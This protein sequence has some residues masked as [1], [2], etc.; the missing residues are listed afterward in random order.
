MKLIYNNPGNIRPGQDFAGETGEFYTAEDGSQYVIFDSPEM[1]LRALF[2]DLRLKI[3]QFNGNIDNIVN[4]YAPPADN[5]PT[6]SYVSFVKGQLG[7]ETVSEDDL[8]ELVSAFVRFENKKS[9][10]DQYLAPNILQTAQKL[11]LED[12]P[13]THRLSDAL[14]QIQ[15]SEEQGALPTLPTP[16]PDTDLPIITE[17]QPSVATLD[18]EETDLP[19]ITERQRQL[20][21]QEDTIANLALE[22]R[23]LRER[24]QLNLKADETILTPPIIEQR[25]NT[26]VQSDD[27]QLDLPLIEERVRP[28]EGEDEAA[29]NIDGLLTER[30]EP[31]PLDLA[32]PVPIGVQKEE[33]DK[34]AEKAPEQDTIGKPRIDPNQIQIRRPFSLLEQ[35]KAERLYE[36]DRAKV[37]FGQAVDAAFAEENTMSW[38][39]SG[40][41]DYEPNP[42]FRLTPE[43]I[44]E[45]TEGIPEDRRRFITEAVS[46]PH[47]QKLRERAL[48]SL[49]NQETLTKYGWGG[50]GLQVAAATL[51]VPAIAATVFTE[52]ALAPFIWGGKATRLARTFRAAASSGASAAAIESYLVSQNAM[53]D[54]YDILYAAA[55][56]F[57][58]GGTTD[59]VF[60]A[61]SRKRYRDA[62][63]KTMNDVDNAQAAD[64]NTAMMDRGID[65]GVGA[66]VNPLSRPMQDF[67]IRRGTI[68]QIDET[69][70]EPMAF[71]G[72]VRFDIVGQLKSSTIGLTRRIA[73]ILGEDAVEPG[74]FTADLIK[75]VGTKR[76]TNKFYRT[77]DPAYNE[78]AKSS[79]INGVARRVDSRKSEFGRL[80]SDEV[81]EPGSSTNPHIIKAANNTRSLFKNMLEEA[82]RAEV[83]GFDSIPENPKYFSHLWDGHRYLQAKKDFGKLLPELLKKSLLTANRTL[84][85]DMADAIAKGMVKKI[86]KRE[87]GM[88]AGLSRMFSTS[89]KEALRD[90]L[91]EE[92]IVTEAQADRIINQLDFD[93]E[94]VSP[95]ARRR[96]EFDLSASVELN[97][98]TLHIKD[99]M[100]RDTEAVVNAYVNQMQGRI[101]LAKKGIK[102]DADFE[103]IKKDIIAA[104]EELNDVD[105]AARDIQKL[106]VLHAL[107]SGRTSPL[108]A[109]PSSDGNRVIRLLM[110]YSFIR[111][112]N[113]VGFAQVAELGNAVSIDG[114]T[115]LLRVIP[116]WRAMV[117]RTANGELEDR[118]SRELEALVAPGVDRNIHSALNKFSYEDMYGLGKGDIIDKAIGVMQPLKRFTADISGLAGITALFERTAAKIA[119][120]SLVDLASGVRKV[121]MKRLGNS[122]LDQDIARRLKSLGLDEEMWPRVVNQIKQH[123]I[124]VPSMFS[125]KRKIKA[126]NMDDW[127]DLDARD[128][129]AYSI[130]RW[131]RQS[132]QQ[133][134]V[135]NLNIHMTSTM[136]KVLTQ[137]RAFMLVSW[138]KQFLHNIERRDFAAFSSM[139]WSL[140][141]GGNA[142]ILQTHVNALGREDKR[143]FLEERLS[144]TEIGKAAFV[145]SSWASLFPSAIDT[146]L[147]VA[148]ADPFFGF[149]RSTGLATDLVTGNPVFDLLDTTQSVVR[150]GSRALFNEEYQW[151]R[152]QQRA[153]NSLLFFQN[154]IGVKNVLNTMMDGL[155]QSA[156]VTE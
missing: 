92:E 156:R 79:G 21:P 51:D 141:Y 148:G 82:K 134:D 16:K 9:L 68:E 45:L 26:Q 115:A 20:V 75:T 151:S 64:V 80:V 97:G 130:A 42:D 108:I 47:A 138:S 110:D 15:S 131:T 89:N 105:Q 41:P 67:D 95:R 135:G 85:E 117:A 96:L 93:R 39:F 104:G 22:K 90:I 61:I 103:K 81:E 24:Q 153:L 101:A 86:I 70:A 7:K 44:A 28:T 118:V 78:W 10:A 13:Q 27:S 142:Y 25:Q 106:E 150:G 145:R 52:G 84:E 17:R 49:K 63:L 140:F 46:L 58:L 129:L 83:K 76:V 32:E 66:M 88:D 139:M 31:N 155:P 147:A 1:G 143:E 126:I 59:S 91:L 154:A 73:S 116:E 122:S 124:S 74:E 48:A 36:E 72:K 113:Q 3:K 65:T 99:L 137:F 136:G 43:N 152:G 14:L 94:G 55:G 87:I 54:P 11:S 149:K 98:K 37:T 62:G 71:M 119:L 112:M 128:A 69:D 102:S 33:Q 12:M 77:Y 132:I 127:D 18:D 123:T 8:P 30:V 50:V 19:I 53:K 114:T 56:G 120:Q 121:R 35:Q 109:N 38:I 146:T 6:S 40:L 125:R 133:N 5:N 60:G 57:V 2:I 29:S 144:V 4:K 34:G 23:M 100:E 111:V 107:I